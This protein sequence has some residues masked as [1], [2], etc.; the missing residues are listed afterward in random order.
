MSAEIVLLQTTAHAIGETAQRLTAAGYALSSE[1]GRIV[2]RPIRSVPA[3]RS[4]VVEIFA[5]LGSGEAR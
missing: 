2:A 1:R 3:R 5:W 4:K